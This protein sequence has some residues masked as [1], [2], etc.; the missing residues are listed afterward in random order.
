MQRHFE[1]FGDFIAPISPER[2]LSEFWE[3]DFLHL[4]NSPGLF[5]HLFSIHD[6]DRWLLS[7]RSGPG[8]SIAIMTLEGSERG[9]QRFRPQDITLQTVYESFA[10][11][12]SVVLN[13]LVSC[14]PPLSGLVKILG[15]YYCADLGVNVYVTPKGK[16]T[17]A[18]HVD[19]HDTFIL[20]VNG[21]K[22]WRLQ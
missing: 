10:S 1:D 15:G 9:V 20:E 3:K 5:D 11:G 13:Y 4:R 18:V 7:V 14:W 8:D 12:H 19:D 6:V 21:E 17:F 22:V 16:R 2:F